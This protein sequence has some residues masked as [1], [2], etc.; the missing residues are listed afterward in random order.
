MPQ[1]LDQRLAQADVVFVGT[2]THVDQTGRLAT[3]Q[4]EEIWR[5]PELASVVE[6]RGAVDGAAFTSVDRRFEQSMRYL[7]APMID[8]NLLVDDA[9]SPTQPYGVE[10]TAYR[11]T[12][13]REPIGGVPAPQSI[14]PATLV[15]AAAALAGIAGFIVLGTQTLV[16]R[17][18]AAS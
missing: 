1:P 11:P 5:G 4:V 2:V 14:G 13:V 10:T 9:C 18:A 12:N 8:G 6:V 16:R 7:F 15:V 3:V 17:R